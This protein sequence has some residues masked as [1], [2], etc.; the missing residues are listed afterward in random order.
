MDLADREV[1]TDEALLWCREHDFQYF[2]TSAKDNS[3]VEEAFVAAVKRF[4][5]MESKMDSKHRM[6]GET[7]DLKT[8][9]STESSCC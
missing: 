9:K 4:L 6:A 5:E 1:T 7:I 2:E 3:G 8:K